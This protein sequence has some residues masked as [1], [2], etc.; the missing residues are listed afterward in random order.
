M[1]TAALVLLN[2]ELAAARHGEGLQGL[3]GE[4]AAGLLDSERLLIDLSRTLTRSV[5]PG[6]ALSWLICLC[7]LGRVSK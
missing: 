4:Q 1:A 6:S 3:I 7:G 2:G 5:S